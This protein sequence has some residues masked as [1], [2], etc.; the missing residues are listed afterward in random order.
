MLKSFISLIL[1]NYNLFFSRK[2]VS[3]NTLL[4][5][6]PP[7]SSLLFPQLCLIKK[8]L[9]VK[10][11]WKTSVRISILNVDTKMLHGT[12]RGQLDYSLQQQL[13]WF[14]IIFD[15][16]DNTQLHQHFSEFLLLI[17]ERKRFCKLYLCK[18]INDFSI[19][20]I[21]CHAYIHTINELTAG[22]LF[23]LEQGQNNHRRSYK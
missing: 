5:F 4:I 16:M 19:N 9:R 12:H 1:D 7:F 8:T 21:N 6:F 17:Y 11:A 18:R 23:V 3:G 2:F 10:V 14:R 20:L 15:K 13:D 22:L